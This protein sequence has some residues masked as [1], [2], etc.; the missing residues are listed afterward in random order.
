MSIIHGVLKPYTKHG[1]GGLGAVENHVMFDLWCT[2]V[3][4]DIENIIFFSGVIIYFLRFLGTFL[5][6]GHFMYTLVHEN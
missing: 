6:P 2:T 4:L 5:V 3:R 1:D